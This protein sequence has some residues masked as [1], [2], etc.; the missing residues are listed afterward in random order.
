MR[1]VAAIGLAQLVYSA[2]DFRWVLDSNPTRYADPLVGEGLLL[3]L[4][5]AAGLAYA[6]AH[7]LA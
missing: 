3:A 4:L 2:V 7:A 6:A 1:W 5:I